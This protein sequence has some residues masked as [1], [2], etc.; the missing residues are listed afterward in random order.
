MIDIP[1][2]VQ[3]WLRNLF[4]RANDQA[5]M[6]LDNNPFSY[7]EHLDIS[8]IEILQQEATTV[9]FSS[10]W[11]VKIDTHFLGKTRMFRNFE[12]ADI[13][14]IA[15]FRSGGKI[16]R[17]KVAL[18]QS[19]RLY[20]DSIEPETNAQFRERY[21]MGFSG[22]YRSDDEFASL[23]EERIIT[24]DDESKYKALRGNSEQCKLIDAYETEVQIPVYY[25][26]YNP[27]VVPLSVTVPASSQRVTRKNEVGLR[28]VPAKNL[29]SLLG[30]ST[31]SPTYLDICKLPRPFEGEDSGGW[32]LEK[33][34]VDLFLQCKVGRIT[35]LRN[36][37]GL[38]NVFYRRSGP[39]A[40]ALSVT[41][42]APAGFEWDVIPDVQ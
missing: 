33:F 6:K 40:A 2:D 24:F 15:I 13:G 1:A 17:S 27:S 10:D 35:D 41:I 32:R 37:T 16:V 9:R 7:E 29:H 19:K 4:Q 23:L 14:F 28:V 34:V 31:G 22:L 20:P 30:T 8:V 12:V 25:L 18:L 39:I 21:E 26:L 42:D 38:Y 11:T 5:T 36:D 3:N